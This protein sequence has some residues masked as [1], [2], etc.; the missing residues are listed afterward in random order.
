[1][2]ESKIGLEAEFVLL[3]KEGKAIVP[4]AYWERD[5]FPLL[6]E[7]RGEP[8]DDMANVVASFLKK[9]LLA[10][11]RIK[12]GNELVFTDII[13]VPLATYKSAMKQV[14]EP[15][16]EAVGKVKNIYG[17]NIDDFSDQ[18]ISKGKI[19]GINASCGLRIHFSR[20][21]VSK[22]VVREDEYE[23]VKI[24]LGLDIV[25]SIGAEDLIDNFIKPEIRLYKR[26]DS[27]V[28]K[29]LEASVSQLNR[30]TVEWIVKQMDEKFFDKFAPEENKRTKYRQAGFYELKDYGF[31]Y[32]SLPAN[33]ASLGA[34]PEIVDFAFK[35][36]NSLNEFN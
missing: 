19:Q 18:I 14:T 2:L 36:L 30:P 6:G 21:D 17:I 34:L 27:N 28:K 13:K 25:G 23:L 35:L 16:G 20:S 32:R 10:E 12:R 11:A 26:V 31:E 1:M 4:P 5:G 7:I 8:G 22:T 9:R 29:T 3:G 15:K 24:P 33:E